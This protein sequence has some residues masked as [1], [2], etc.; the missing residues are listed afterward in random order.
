MLC[1]GGKLSFPKLGMSIIIA[2]LYKRIYL[3]GPTY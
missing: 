2:E 1:I 3:I